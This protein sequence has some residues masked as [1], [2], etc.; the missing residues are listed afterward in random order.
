VA[1][2]ASWITDDMRA[3]LGSELGR[4]VSFPVLTKIVLDEI[5]LAGARANPNV[6]A[7]VINLFARGIL[8]GEK[9][10]THRFPLEKYEEA[11]QTFTTRKDGAIKVVVEP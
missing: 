10:V 5:T 4:K 8:N 2:T 9:I 7:E 6:S 3:A 1:V 11:F